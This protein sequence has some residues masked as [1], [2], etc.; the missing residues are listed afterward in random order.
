MS[1]LAYVRQ[2]HERVRQACRDA[3]IERFGRVR[4]NEG[5]TQS[6]PPR[7]LVWILKQYKLKC[8]QLEAEAFGRLMAKA[9]IGSDGNLEFPEGSIEEAKM[10][11]PP[12]FPDWGYYWNFVSGEWYYVPDMDK[13]PE[14]FAKQFVPQY[15]RILEFYGE[16]REEGCTPHEA[17]GRTLG[18]LNHEAQ[19]ERGEYYPFT[20]VPQRLRYFNQAQ[21][22][23]IEYIQKMRNG[24]KA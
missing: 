9:K 11:P 14:W 12:G 20:F 18:A 22:R 13:Y 4:A 16:K 3:E 23:R 6:P 5:W 1:N 15:Q 17:M 7:R 19:E 2:E 24:Q 10:P 8:K 21:K